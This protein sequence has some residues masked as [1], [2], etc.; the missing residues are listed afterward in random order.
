LLR[1][2]TGK[3]KKGDNVKTVMLFLLLSAA[4]ALGV[5]QLQYHNGSPHW[6]FNGGVSRG[7]WFDLE[8]FTPGATEFTVEWAEIWL[9][10]SRAPVYV[11]IWSGGGSGPGTLLAQQ[12]IT[13]DRVWFDEP[14]VT[15]SEFWCV[16]ASADQVC[17]LADG[18]ADEHSY[19]TDD[20]LVWECFDIGEFL[21]TVGNDAEALGQH[22]WGALKTVF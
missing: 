10:S 11:E 22:S 21:I 7:T 2:W 17:I 9:Y 14:V 18:E 15:G 19:F 1:E 20:G 13:G 8:D 12:E 4:S 16:V 3:H 5:Q 6:L